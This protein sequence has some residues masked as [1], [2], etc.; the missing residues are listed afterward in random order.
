M[1]HI[2]L[3][4]ALIFLVWFPGAATI[5]VCAQ[6]RPEP[7]VFDGVSSASGIMARLSQQVA[8]QWQD[9][10][11]IQSGPWPMGGLPGEFGLYSGMNPKG[12]PALLRLVAAGGSGRAFVI[13]MSVL[14]NE[15]EAN[16]TDLQHIEESFSAGN[17]QQ[18]ANQ[19]EGGANTG[20]LASSR[21]NPGQL[22]MY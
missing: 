10:H 9:F 21:A 18:S 5:P 11:Q 4:A 15:W 8:Q 1:R 19:S 3:G 20:T 7:L 6:M 16:K 13:L 2:T 17:A 14:Q 22:K 12:V